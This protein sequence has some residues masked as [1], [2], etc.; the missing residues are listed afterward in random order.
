MNPFHR[1][2]PSHR[3]PV[4]GFL[5]VFVCAVLAFS[6]DTVHASIAY[7]SI[8]NF[9][10]V[11]DT[12][13]E[14]HGFEIELE[15]CHSTDITYTYN[16]NHYG[17][18]EI[19]EDNSVAGHPK[20]TIRWQSKKNADGSWAAYTAIPAGPISP[21]NGHMFTNPAINFGGE[22]FGVGYR[23]QPTAVRYQWLIDNGAGVLVPGGAVQVSTPTF[24]YFPPQGGNVAQV[25]AVIAPPP[26]E[27]PDPKEFGKPVWVKEIR[28]TTHNNKEVKLRDLVSD[29]PDDA[30]DKDWRNG[31][32]DEVEVEW[33]LLQVDHNRG[34]G[35][36]NNKVPAAAEDLPGGDEVVTRRYEFYKYI[37]PI[38]EESGEA[39][40]ENVAADDIHGEG[41]KT[42]NGVSVDLST[43]A[44]V[45][46]YTG[47]QMSAVDVDAP[48]GL[49]DHVGEARVNTEFAARTVVVAG[50]LPFSCAQEGALPAGMSFDEV[51]GVL[52]GNPAESGTFEF[53]ITAADG[54]NPEVSKNYTLVVAEA[55]VPLPPGNL[56]D[57]AALPVGSGTTTGDGPYMV[58]ANATVTAIS[59]PG[60]AFVNWTDNGTVVSSN[61]AFTLVM[62]VNHS[63]VANFQLDGLPLIT[64]QPQAQTVNPG[65]NVTFSVIATGTGTL[66]YQWRKNEKPIDGATAS[67]YSLALVS[68]ADQAG[69]DVVINDDMGSKAS[70]LAQLSVNDPAVILTDPQ[71]QAL[72][73]GDT[74]TFSVTVAGTGPFS[75][76]WRK[77]V[78]DLDGA[79]ESTLVLADLTQ[80]DEGTYSV[81][82]TNDVNEAIS[83]GAVL[84]VTAGAPVIVGLTPPQLVGINTE[85]TLEVTAEGSG[86]L[87]YQWSKNRVAI[88][89][90]TG[91]R[92]V[93]AAAQIKDAG[94]YQV[95]VTGTSVV[96]SDVIQLGVVDDTA[97][98]VPLVLGGRTKIQVA[99]EGAALSFAWQKNGEPV[100]ENSR[101]KGA[102]QKSLDIRS[103]Q[104]GDEGLY[105]LVVTGPGGQLTTKGHALSVFSQAPVIT[106][107][108]PNFPPA[109]VSGSF[110]YWI[111]VDLDPA[112]TPSA[113]AAT[114]LPPG[115]KLDTRT[116]QISGKP[117]AIAKDPLG[118]LVKLTA[119]NAKGRASVSGRL[120][121]Q[122]LPVNAMGTYT[123]PIGRENALN[124][125]LG[126]VMD[127]TITAAGAY[128]GRLV[129]GTV[130]YPIRGVLNAD[131]TGVQ[132]EAAL[133]VA[134]KGQTP[135]TFTFTVDPPANA[136]A[137]QLTDGDVTLGFVGWR[138][139]WDA[140]A[141]PADT[142]AGYHTFALDIPVDLAGNAAIPQGNGYGSFTVSAGGT[143]MVA[144]RLADGEVVTSSTFVGPLGEIAI[145]RALYTTKP[146]GSVVGRLDIAPPVLSGALSWSRP[147]NPSATQRLYK[148][149]FPVVVNLT[150]SGGRYD[151]PEAPLVFLG[152]TQGSN[153]GRLT[154]SE[155]GMEAANV[156]D[157]VEV[158]IG[159]KSKVT[160][161]VSP[162]ANPHRL[163]LV[164][165]EKTG[166]IR[167]SFTLEDANPLAAPALPRA[168]KRPV[169]FEGI[170]VRSGALLKGCGFFLLA[171]LPSAGP[172]AT[173]PATSPILSGQVILEAAPPLAP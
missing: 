18:P 56:L 8:N 138:K 94:A 60:Y 169:A 63:L 73:V 130:T 52:S 154:F 160:L 40:A 71:S 25:Q 99:C 112:K 68:E 23:V 113:Y 172:S 77:G 70:H 32:P 74:V 110:E 131:A 37:G 48:V 66:S 31:E 50:V 10:T 96:S 22:H 36:N 136:I 115:L 61:P 157:P 161:P 62:D 89:K 104:A 139:V 156:L 119:S 142:F 27:A 28:T 155:G 21:T 117:T 151:P 134:R 16:Y 90:A 146:K 124:D 137:A 127:L 159:A 47:A 83:A 46:D 132:P 15:D 33:Q 69:Y 171:Q 6:R 35:G 39:M 173:T 53:K 38:D 72:V 148:A 57:T 13:H 162:A 29:D 95:T 3:L 11:N 150:A 140:K 163:T 121:V 170:A 4:V 133:T 76:Q 81:A 1:H 166:L 165:N 59:E 168:I 51:T 7:G 108:P 41:V 143:L 106:E 79:T 149:G 147:A 67:T 103:L 164:L 102:D 5:L 85:V 128:T 153:N 118:Y 122:P 88:A 30:D 42:I 17:V 100:T 129:L 123:G 84:T 43:L 26:P 111:P 82:V 126:G 24:N 19:T 34:D 9:D 87:T 58:G 80:T 78:S 14:C 135:L 12:G 55:D 93:L 141:H 98:T 64:Q 125:D 49:I 54:E 144:G 145:Y 2:P 114:G 97:H 91:S 120:V 101:I 158:S 65:A 116:G 152:L 45:G 92:L 167:G 75:Y 109:I 86:E 105:E 44:V 20:C 107:D